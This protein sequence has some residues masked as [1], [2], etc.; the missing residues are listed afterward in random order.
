M[1]LSNRGACRWGE[2]TVGSLGGP[3]GGG[4]GGLRARARFSLGSLRGCDPEWGWFHSLW[5]CDLGGGSMVCGAV[6]RRG[7]GST[8]SEGQR[9]DS[10]RSGRLCEALGPLTAG[11]GAP[12]GEARREM[13]PFLVPDCCLERTAAGCSLKTSEFSLKYGIDFSRLTFWKGFKYLCVLDKVRKQRYFTDIQ[14]ELVQQG[15]CRGVSA[16]PCRSPALG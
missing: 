3:H 1:F 11:R 4:G 9:S 5:G 7:G 13:T 8:G 6:V 15:R 16:T 10:L 14:V 2:T 12:H